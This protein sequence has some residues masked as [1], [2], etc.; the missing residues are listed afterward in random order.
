[1]MTSLIRHQVSTQGYAALDLDNPGAR[2]LAVAWQADDGW[3][4]GV[5]DGRT[6]GSK[7]TKTK[8]LHLMD[9]TATDQLNRA[10]VLALLAEVRR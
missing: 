4:V 8:A 3:R 6:V 10:G 1:M 7:L 5:A 2:A 9:Q